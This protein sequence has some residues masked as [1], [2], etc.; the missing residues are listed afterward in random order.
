[1]AT[2]T[3]RD[4]DDALKAR[5]RVRA[6]SAGRSMEEE[7]R[8][9]LRA[10]LADAPARPVNLGQRIR[11]R[12]APLGDVQLH[13]PAREPVRDPPSLGGGATRRRARRP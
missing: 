2:L 7:V 1:M 11:Q 10:A 13:V 4:I 5:L 6:A 12:F 8:Q 9:I 3:I